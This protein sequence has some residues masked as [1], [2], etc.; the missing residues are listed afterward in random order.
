M[1]RCAVHAA[2][3]GESVQLR[4]LRILESSAELSGTNVLCN[5]VLLKTAIPLEHPSARTDVDSILLVCSLKD[6]VFH[7][8]TNL[9]TL[10]LD[11][12]D[13]GDFSQLSPLFLETERV[14]EAHFRFTQR[15][16]VPLRPVQHESLCVPVTHWSW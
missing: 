2:G 4:F 15:F 6:F 7:V 14:P 11:N 10:A 16:W 9:F 3:V 12:T 8:C 5:K 1:I 13:Y